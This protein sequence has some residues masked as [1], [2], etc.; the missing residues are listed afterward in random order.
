MHGGQFQR[1]ETWEQ[2]RKAV[3][4]GI[5]SGGLHVV[6]VK[7]ERASNVRMH[8]HLWQVVGKALNAEMR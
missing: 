6:E 4:R 5:S 1:A 7:T 2:F 3:M 8:R